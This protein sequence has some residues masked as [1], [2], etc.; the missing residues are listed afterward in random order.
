MA[1]SQIYENVGE[2]I[3]FLYFI[4][5]TLQDSNTINSHDI[6]CSCKQYFWAFLINKLSGES[7]FF[8]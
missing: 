6:L 5:S 7:C 8:S 1:S 2:K 4:V 3:R